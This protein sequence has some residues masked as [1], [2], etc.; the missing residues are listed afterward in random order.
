LPAIEALRADP[1]LLAGCMRWLVQ[2]QRRQEV[3][4]FAACPDGA[5]YVGDPA[6]PTTWRPKPHQLEPAAVLAWCVGHPGDELAVELSAAGR[7]ADDSARRALRR[8]AQA[9]PD[10]RLAGALATGLQVRLADGRVLASWEPPPDA[11]RI[12]FGC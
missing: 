1:P 8:A 11:P 5:Y 4:V 2:E 7:F 9:L 3:R 12:Q 10:S 6:S